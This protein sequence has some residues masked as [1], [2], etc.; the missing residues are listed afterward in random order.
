MTWILLRLELRG[1]AVAAHRA[2][3]RGRCQLYSP[4]TS[5]C[6]WSC[7]AGKRTRVS[8]LTNVEMRK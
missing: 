6:R 8:Y 1:C 4:R 5:P 3:A 7:V 2:H